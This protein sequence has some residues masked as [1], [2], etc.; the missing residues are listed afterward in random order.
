[1]KINI[2]FKI[3]FPIYETEN[4]IK[5]EIKIAVEEFMTRIS[6]DGGIFE[7][8]ECLIEKLKKI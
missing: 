5:N 2:D 1:M 4:V 8:E 7:S 6:N 3:A